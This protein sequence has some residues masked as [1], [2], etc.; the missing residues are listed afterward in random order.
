[1]TRTAYDPAVRKTGALLGVLVTPLLGACGGSA[2]STSGVLHVT[3]P[4]PGMAPTLNTGARVTVKLSHAAPRL[5]ELVGFH[6]P[7]ISNPAELACTD[8]NQG[9]SLQQPCGKPAPREAK[10][11][12]IRRV[13]GLPGDRIAI[14]NGYVIRNGTRESVPH[15]PPCQGVPECSLPKAI[16]VPPGHYYLV[17]D[18]RG[19]SNDSR[20]WGP[21]P[22]AWIIGV[23]ER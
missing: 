17:G 15:L 16:V 14:V 21:V 11:I 9:P 20:F 3:I 23:V 22:R 13:V 8:T 1:M 6:P 4:N 2:S 7:T 5:Y 12:F 19:D 18:D 10:T